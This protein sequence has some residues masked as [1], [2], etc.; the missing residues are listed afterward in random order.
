M[1]IQTEAIRQRAIRYYESWFH[2]DMSDAAHNAITAIG[3]Q[4]T[5]AGQDFELV[6]QS[7]NLS[8]GEYDAIESAIWDGNK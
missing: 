2:D 3:K 4:P 8:A 1:T 7:P 6:S 5:V